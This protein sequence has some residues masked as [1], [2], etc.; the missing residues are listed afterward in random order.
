MEIVHISESFYINHSICN[1][2][3]RGWGS[4]WN[5]SSTGRER[6]DG[7]RNGDNKD[8]GCDYSNVKGFTDVDNFHFPA[9][10][11]WQQKVIPKS[12]PR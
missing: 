12:H 5:P 2:N 6:E 10:T 9:S 1:N 11:T 7:E 4:A 8:Y 3:I